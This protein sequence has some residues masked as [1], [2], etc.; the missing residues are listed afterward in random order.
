M[1]YRELRNFSETMRSLGYPRPVSVESF[2]SPNFELAADCLSWLVERYEPGESVPE[3]LAT[4]KDRVYF[5]RRCAEI[6]LSRARIKLNLKRLYQADGFA[7][8]EL[9]K[10]ASVLYKASMADA[11]HEDGAGGD[12]GGELG[13]GAMAAGDSTE[14]NLGAAANVDVS[15]ARALA[16]EITQLGVSL[17]DS[18]E[19]EGEIRAE[20]ERA[21]SRNTNMGAIER[22]VKEAI[23]AVREQTTSLEGLQGGLTKDESTLESKIEKRRGELER[24]EKR[25]GT[26]Q[27]VRPAYMDELE[28]LQ[29]ELQ[30]LYVVYLE[31]FRNLE[32]LEAAVEKHQVA[33]QQKAERSEQK[34]RKM[35]RRLENEEMAILRGLSELDEE[36]LDRSMLDDEDEDDF[37]DQYSSAPGSRAASRGVGGRTGMLSPGRG[38]SG[39]RMQ[40]TLDTTELDDSDESSVEIDDSS[41]DEHV[42]LAGAEDDSGDPLIGTA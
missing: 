2:R 30:N 42:E 5:L 26:L 32:Y 7:V 37:D 8:R 24:S 20:R 34:L 14:V 12:V 28:R 22:S 11:L 38:G 9:L 16:S 39:G 3:D 25:L 4:V 19:R 21:V 1:S 15:V 6:M 31:R 10:I 23:A 18:L 33:E 36:Q 41:E 13:D 27:A 40:G 17:F 35:Q 29:A